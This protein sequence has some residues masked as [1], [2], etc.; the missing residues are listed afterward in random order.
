[1]VG[2]ATERGL[3]CYKDLIM[4]PWKRT[5][6][7]NPECFKQ[8]LGAIGLVKEEAYLYPV[9]DNEVMT[10]FTCPECG[11]HQTWGVTRRQVQKILYERLGRA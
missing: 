3:R 4:E 9:I 6:C 1:M 5:V 8:A 10:Q 2:G 7:E 11:T